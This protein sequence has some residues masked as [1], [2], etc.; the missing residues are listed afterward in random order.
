MPARFLF[1]IT[2]TFEVKG[3][4]CVEPLVPFALCEGERLKKGD[5]LELRKPDG[6]VVQTTLFGLEWPSPSRGALIMTLPPPLTKNDVPAGTEI[7]KMRSS[8]T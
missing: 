1:A 7:W 6:S 3:I 8:N 5:I 4:V 2:G